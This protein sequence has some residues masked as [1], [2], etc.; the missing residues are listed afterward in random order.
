MPVLK[1]CAK[2]IH[3]LAFRWMSILLFAVAFA[4]CMVAKA[5]T[6]GDFSYETD[7]A[8]VAI[9][10]YAGPGGAVTIPDT[11]TNKPVTS[12]GYLA[13]YRCTRLTS[14][15]IPDSVTSIGY[16]AFYGCSGLRS[17][18]VGNSVT[19]IGSLAFEGCTSLTGAYFR[20]D[21][22]RSVASDVFSGADKATVYYRP[23]TLGWGA[24]F[25]GRPAVRW[26]P[27]IDVK[28]A[29]FGVT[30]DG[31]G[32]RITGTTNIPIVVEGCADLAGGA[33]VPLQS[34]SLTNGWFDFTDPDW[35]N[36]AARF[37][38]TSSP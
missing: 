34:A 24:T 22:P 1:N 16:A 17:A 2:A 36:H 37:Y 23:G 27:V 38:R 18:T 8:T 29:C 10:G 4:P 31:F 15:T 9:A 3:R 19:F 25:G 14:V 6:W 35:T 13:F 20:G 11:I 33:W 32:F 5:A 7:G 30:A 28:D 26:D 12:I 21:A